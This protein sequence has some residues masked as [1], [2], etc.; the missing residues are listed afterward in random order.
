TT[1]ADNVTE[2]ISSSMAL[3]EKKPIVVAESTNHTSSSVI[4]SRATGTGSKIRLSGKLA[5][6]KLHRTS[7]ST[8]IKVRNT[9]NNLP[10]QKLKTFADSHQINTEES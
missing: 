4:I 2:K 1:L 10:K 7:P 3:D 9:E 8:Q 5:R 6:W